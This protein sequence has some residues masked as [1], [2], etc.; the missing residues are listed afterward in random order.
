MTLRSQY[1]PDALSLLKD[2]A[3]KLLPEGMFME[4]VGAEVWLMEVEVEKE[5]K[6]K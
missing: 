3:A 6:Y 5:A 1:F 2:M 4:R